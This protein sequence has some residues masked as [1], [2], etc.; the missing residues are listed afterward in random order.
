MKNKLTLLIAMLAT[1]LLAGCLST[2]TT[3]TWSKVKQ[4]DGS[5]VT[6]YSKTIKEK[7]Q[8]PLK[9]KI[10]RTTQKTVGLDLQVM[11]APT[12]TSGGLSPLKL[13]FG[14]GK[15]TWVTIPIYRE[16]TNFYTPSLAYAASGAGSLWNDSDVENL[17][18]APSLLPTNAYYATPL[19]PVNLITPTSGTV[20]PQTT[21]TIQS[22]TG[23]NGATTV[24]TN[25]V[26]K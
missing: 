16:G 23:T 14:M 20:S 12:G 21:T 9:D 17:S 26:T 18:T 19:T 4:P 25:T 8:D 5:Y 10:V 1:A 3:E 11:P 13:F 15:M 22:V 6:N 24:T 7:N 2:K